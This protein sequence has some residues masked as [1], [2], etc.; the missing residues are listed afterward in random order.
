MLVGD[1]GD[2]SERIRVNLG[3]EVTVCSG[4]IPHPG[5][6]GGACYCIEVPTGLLL[7]AAPFC[8]RK[9]PKPRDDLTIVSWEDVGV[10][11]PEGVEA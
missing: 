2:Y 11:R 9:L 5:I 1:D 4:L 10:W 7:L 6:T 8:L 3:H